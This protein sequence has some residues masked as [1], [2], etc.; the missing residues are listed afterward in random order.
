MFNRSQRKRKYSGGLATVKRRRTTLKRRYTRPYRRIARRRSTFRRRT[1]GYAL[2]RF[3]PRMG[4]SK[5]IAMGTYF[6]GTVKSGYLAKNM[7]RKLG[8]DHFSRTSYAW[9]SSTIGGTNNTCFWIGNPLYDYVHIPIGTMDAGPTTW[10]YGSYVSF[11]PQAEKIFL[12]YLKIRLVVQ[13]VLENCGLRLSIA[14]M[15][16]NMPGTLSGPA[17]TA[18]NHNIYQPQNLDN[19]RVFYTKLIKFDQPLITGTDISTTNQRVKT[20]DYYIPINRIIKTNDNQHAAAQEDWIGNSTNYEWTKLFIDT[21]DAT[22][23]DSE[24]LGFNIYFEW[25]WSQ[26]N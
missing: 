7:M 16:K 10:G 9:K 12:R 25:G 21:D 18:W 5:Q 19:W 20:F 8:D 11:Y 26:M 23:A 24:Y 22:S 4:Y 1:S 17:D 3:T 13:Q 6:P 14:R 15:R 2:T